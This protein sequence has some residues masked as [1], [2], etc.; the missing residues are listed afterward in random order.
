MDVSLIP[1]NTRMSELF[2]T[3]AIIAIVINM[4]ELDMIILIWVLLFVSINKTKKENVDIILCNKKTSIYVNVCCSIWIH[5]PR[6]TLSCG[7]TLW[8]I[9]NRFHEGDLWA[10]FT[11]PNFTIPTVEFSYSCLEG[12]RP[13]LGN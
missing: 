10:L 7:I 9:R 4:K 5:T 1:T 6:G 11:E 13:R 8:E 3:R 2:D 12:S